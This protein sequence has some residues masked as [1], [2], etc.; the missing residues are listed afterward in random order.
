MI[1][2]FLAGLMR[3]NDAFPDDIPN[4]GTTLTIVAIETISIKLPVP[5][6]PTDLAINTIVAVQSR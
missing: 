6:E 1:I 5:I 2:N 3:T 4:K